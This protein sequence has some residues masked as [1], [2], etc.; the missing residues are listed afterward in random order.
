MSFLN[1]LISK[2]EARVANE[3]FEL[4]EKGFYG[5]LLGIYSGA[6]EYSTFGWH[7]YIPHEPTE[8]LE[9]HMKK[10]IDDHPH[11]ASLIIRKNNIGKS[12]TTNRSPFACVV[13]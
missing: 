4:V 5:N 13:S 12:T 11:E 7:G 8:E 2:Q 9:K 6:E 10:W 1:T 3:E